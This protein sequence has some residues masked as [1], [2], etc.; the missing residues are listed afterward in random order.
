VTLGRPE[1]AADIALLLDRL[2]ALARAQVMPQ[3][4]TEAQ[5]MPG[6]QGPGQ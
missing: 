3:R 5:V 2:R 1:L 4:L 6:A